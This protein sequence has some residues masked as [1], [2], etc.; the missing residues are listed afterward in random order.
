M[1]NTECL[2]HRETYY[3]EA[4][5]R[6]MEGR[7]NPVYVTLRWKKYKDIKKKVRRVR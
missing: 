5:D 1:N 3:Y 7:E 2:K 6:L 4:L